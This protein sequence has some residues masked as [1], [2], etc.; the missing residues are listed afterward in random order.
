MLSSPI[1][2]SAVLIRLLVP[3][4]RR[5]SGYMEGWLSEVAAQRYS[6]YQMI[7]LIGV[8]SAITDQKN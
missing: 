6:D 4:N 8:L 2:C 7:Q 5:K 1:S 3:L